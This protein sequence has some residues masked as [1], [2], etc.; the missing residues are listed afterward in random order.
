M[1]H[2]H[3][4]EKIGRNA[5]CPC[6]SGKKY[7]RCC[8][9]SASTRTQTPWERQ[10]AASDHLTA[11][12]REFSRKHFGEESLRAWIDFNQT[13]FPKPLDEYPGEAQ[14]FVPYFWFDWDPERP[15]VRSRRKPTPGIVVGAFL[16]EKADE[17]SDLERLI[18]YENI[19]EPLSFYEVIRCEPGRGMS[20]LDVLIGSEFDVE[21]HAGSETLRQG[22]LIYA[23]LCRLPDVTTVGRMTPVALP[24]AYKADVVRLRTK[25]TRKIAKKGRALVAEDLRWYRDEIRTV[26]L[27]TRDARRRPPVLCNT[28]REPLLFHTLTF[29]VGSAQVAFDALASLAWG[30]TKEELLQAAEFDR[31]GVL[32]SIRFDWRR[33]GNAMHKTW[34]NTILGHLNISGRK[35]TA[36]VNSAMRAERIRGEIERRMGIIVVHEGTQVRTPQEIMDAPK[37]AIRQSASEYDEEIDPEVLQEF[38]SQMQ[39]EMENWVDRR[40]PI[41]GNRT[42]REAIADPDGLEIVESL[43]LQ[44]E[45]NNEKSTQ[46]GVF[47]PDVSAVRRLLNL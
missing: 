2:S 26:Y 3:P 46:P 44:W 12:L 23:Q 28:D 45:R 6:G 29:R 40:I 38:Q 4:R 39:A 17:L 25:L 33:K 11:E 19:T 18:L 7:K 9:E 13:S 16:I 47:R 5:F 34:D 15:P 21:E 35:L 31:E 43:L 32:C 36:D 42:P 24:P 20:L 10:R 27:N 22:D 30:E 37:G 1:S 41:L 14:I 8:L